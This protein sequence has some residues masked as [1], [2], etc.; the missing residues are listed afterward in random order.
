[1]VIMRLSG[2]RQMKKSAGKIA[3]V[4]LEFIIALVTIIIFLSAM[5][6]FVN[7]AMKDMSDRYKAYESTRHD[8]IED[9]YSGSRPELK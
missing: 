1:M 6:K 3:Q 9:F 5:L 7:W 8:I 2:T 4:A